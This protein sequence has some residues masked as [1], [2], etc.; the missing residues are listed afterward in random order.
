[1]I[2][3]DNAPP[4]LDPQVLE[5][6]QTLQR[7]SNPQL[8]QELYSLYRKTL[9]DKGP[10][11]REAIAR[12]D[13]QALFQSAHALKSS[14]ANV[15]A[16]EFARLLAEIE[17]LGRTGQAASAT[18]FLERFEHEYSRVQAAVAAVLAQQTP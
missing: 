12:A 15:G 5:Q 11:V 4:A 18:S 9:V 16:V 1:M 2:V 17:L 6:L 10:L 13:N 3:S 8:L 7:I 14:S